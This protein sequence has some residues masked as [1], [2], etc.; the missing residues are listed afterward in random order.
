M[1]RDQIIRIATRGSPLALAQAEEVRERLLELHGELTPERVEILPLKTTG[2]RIQDRT[3]Q[4]AGGKGLFTKEIEEALL[5]GRADLAVHSMKD[6]PVEYPEGLTVD[7]ILP[8]EDARD[9]LISPIATSLAGLPE[10]AVVGTASLRRQALTLL[11]RPDFSV[12][13]FRGNV[14]TRLAKL[15]EGQAQATYLAVAGLNRLGYQEHITA[16]LEPTVMLP[17]VA[18]GAIGVQ[19]RLDD[20]RIAA[21][22][23][24]LNCPVSASRITAERAML[25][26]LDGSCRTPI[27]GYA[28]LLDDGSTLWLRGSITHPDGSRHAADEITGPLADAYGLGH[29]LGRRLREHLPS[30]LPDR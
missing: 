21:L 6:M 24:P 11:I 3:L 18:Q 30:V 2:D 8:R 14:Q 7:C 10:R 28:E 5:D 15:A 23:A 16:V 29:E 20:E 19:R 17:A 12:I 25:A 1:T 13:P 22:L 9:A 27:A 4:E 26:V